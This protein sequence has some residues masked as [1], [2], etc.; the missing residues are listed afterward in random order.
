MVE[1]S[2]GEPYILK[3]VIVYHVSFFLKDHLA[4]ILYATSQYPHVLLL[5]RFPRERQRIIG[6]RR[7]CPDLHRQRGRSCKLRERRISTQSRSR[8]AQSIAQSSP[9]TVRHHQPVLR[10]TK[11]KKENRTGKKKT[12]RQPN[13][14]YL[15]HRQQCNGRFAWPLFVPAFCK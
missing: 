5:N 1:P 15:T 7:T 2:S 12:C 13:F 14:I 9:T 8:N 3:E 11:K 10:R 4:A 6:T